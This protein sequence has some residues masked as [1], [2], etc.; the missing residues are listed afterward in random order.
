MARDATGEFC[1]LPAGPVAE[2]EM[3]P[4]DVRVVPTRKDDLVKFLLLPPYRGVNKRIRCHIK[5]IKNLSLIH[6]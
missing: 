4:Y 5:R 1:R 3:N 6:I 2:A